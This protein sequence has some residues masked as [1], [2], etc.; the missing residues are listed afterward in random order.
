MFDR[1]QLYKRMVRISKIV[2]FM[3]A[4]MILFS[5]VNRAHAESVTV[6]KGMPLYFH[7]IGT[8]GGT[9]TSTHSEFPVSVRVSPGRQHVYEEDLQGMYTYASTSLHPWPLVTMW[10]S[11]ITNSAEKKVLGEATVEMSIVS[12]KGTPDEKLVRFVYPNCKI[13]K[14][15]D[16]K[17]QSCILKKPTISGDIPKVM[18]NPHL[19]LQFE[20]FQKVPDVV[21]FWFSADAPI[22]APRDLVSS[23][24]MPLTIVPLS[25]SVK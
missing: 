1:K 6:A 21:N 12:A 10:W 24:I 3:V 7:A 9:L 25:D 18:V 13:K 22:S 2:F 8:Y 23:V 16:G 20:L 4:M 15:I 14:A 5:G 17:G 11:A 19:T